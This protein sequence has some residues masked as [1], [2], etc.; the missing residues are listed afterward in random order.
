[1]CFW[2]GAE[3]E[4]TERA[5]QGSHSTLSKAQVK[6]R[7]HDRRVHPIGSANRRP[8][9]DG[10]AHTITR[11]TEQLTSTGS[12]GEGFRS[13]AA[14]W[15][16]V[17]GHSLTSRDNLDVFSGAEQNASVVGFGG[18]GGEPSP[19]TGEYASSAPAFLS[20]LRMWRT[21]ERSARTAEPR[22]HVPR[23]ECAGAGR[24]AGVW[25]GMRSTGEPL[26]L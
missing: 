10:G 23:L 25:V 22:R 26:L 18:I 3:A 2:A 19:V 1:V 7:P 15:G 17:L 21:P 20:S 13:G 11:N 6:R 9:T 5:R 8:Y 14:G 16:C 4:R 24:Q 12:S